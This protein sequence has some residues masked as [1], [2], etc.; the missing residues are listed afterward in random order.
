[1][2]C[3]YDRSLSANGSESLSPLLTTIMCFNSG[4]SSR[5]PETLRRRAG[6]VTKIVAPES[7]KRSLTGSGPNAE[8]SGPMT[9]PAFST[10]ITAKYNSGS[11]SMKTKT[12][13]PRFMPRL[14][15]TLAN[16]SDCSLNS[17]KV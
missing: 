8:N 15:M 11:R 4:H 17:A 1:M 12:R 5:I 14:V 13:S 2:S 16:L 10:P 9:P 7:C 3:S 6:S